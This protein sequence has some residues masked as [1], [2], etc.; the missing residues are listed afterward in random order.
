MNTA[1]NQHIN[2]I[3]DEGGRKM[4]TVELL[5]GNSSEVWNKSMSNELGR[6]AQGNYHGVKH[7][8]TIKFINKT[9]APKGKKVTYE[10]FE[11]TIDHSKQNHSALDA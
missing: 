4:T 2:L 3:Y 11:Q 10:N 7:T 8:D 1:K 9:Q 6:L 5:N